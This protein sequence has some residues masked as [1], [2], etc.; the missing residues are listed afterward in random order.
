VQPL[1]IAG[2]CA[3]GGLLYC[4]AEA[5]SYVVREIDMPAPVAASGLRVLHLSD[6]HIAPWDKD[7][8][9]WVASLTELAPDLV[10]AS[11]DF[12][13]HENCVPLVAKAL[14]GLLSRPGVFVLGS[15]DFC[16]RV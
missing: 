15:N 8:A 9:R 6:L 11:G 13:A 12:L 4:L 2:L 14:G 5:R 7:R 3:S 1:S 10:I 16:G